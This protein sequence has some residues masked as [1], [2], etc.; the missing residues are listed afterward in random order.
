MNTKITT[1]TAVAVVTIALLW[2][3]VPGQFSNPQFWAEDG[4]VFWIDQ[5]RYG[6][7]RLFT[8]YNGFIEMA[9]RLIAFGASFFDPSSA[10]RLFAVGAVAFTVWAAVSAASSVSNPLMGLL[11]GSTLAAAP[12]AGDQILGYALSIQWVIAPVAALLLV[13]DAE[14]GK[15]M[16]INNVLFSAVAALTGPFSIVF[17]PVAFARYA[18]RRDVSSLVVL[19]GAVI[20]FLALTKNYPPRTPPTDGTFLHLVDIMIQ[21]GMPA[22]SLSVLAAGAIIAIALFVPEDRRFRLGLIWA[23]FA[24]LAATAFKFRHD[25]HVFDYAHWSPRYFYP[26]QVCIWWCAISLLFVERARAAG[27]MWLTYSIAAYPPGYFERGPLK[28]VNWSEAVRDL[29]DRPLS[30]PINPDGWK[31]EIPAAKP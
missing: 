20:Q 10:P 15:F 23:A 5:H 17:S 28:D 26:F 7:A 9:P 8:P 2:L 4:P 18:R 12:Y 25:P 27:A 30:I 19:A 22:T 1:V 16:K 6:L 21:R 24:I 13:A 3:R 31:V 29:G 14:P 11:L